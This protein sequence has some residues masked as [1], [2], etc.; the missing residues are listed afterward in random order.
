M[1]TLALF[2]TACLFLNSHV[3]RLLELFIHLCP[4][5]CFEDPCSPR[6]SCHS[7]LTN[8]SILYIFTI[9]LFALLIRKSPQNRPGSRIVQREWFLGMTGLFLA[10]QNIHSDYGFILG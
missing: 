9:R 5:F 7:I 8:K 4:S 3:R 10:A 2:K 6:D 1:S